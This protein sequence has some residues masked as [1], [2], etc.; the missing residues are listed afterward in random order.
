MS[1]VPPKLLVTIAGQETKT[2]TLTKPHLTLGRADDNDIV[3][4]SPIVSRHHATL[5]K[6]FSGYEIHILPNVINTLTWQGC[7]VTDRQLLSNADVM[8]IDSEIPGLMVSMTYQDP[9]QATTNISA[10]QFGDKEQ[11]TIGRDPI[12]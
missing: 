8:R 1:N 2:Y 9:S 11:L 7:P 6:T 4:N 3:V 12:Q 5:E 10:V